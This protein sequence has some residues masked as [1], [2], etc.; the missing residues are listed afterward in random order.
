MAKK[1]D[2]EKQVPVSK[3]PEAPVAEAT[4]AEAPG[5]GKKAQKATRH[6]TSSWKE[7]S[8]CA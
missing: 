7:A 4:K 6:P 8:G 3:A 5:E 2:D 1:K